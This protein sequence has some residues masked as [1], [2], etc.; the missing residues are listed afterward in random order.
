MVEEFRN[1][2]SE[3]YEFVMPATDIVEDGSDLVIRVDLPGFAK[4]DINLR[5]SGNI[6]SIKARREAEEKPLA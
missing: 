5:I 6:L 2:S 3:F 1:R 4:K